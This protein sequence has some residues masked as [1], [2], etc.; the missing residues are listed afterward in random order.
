MTAPLSPPE[1]I[2]IHEAEPDR[3]EPRTRRKLMFFD[4]VKVLII[5]AVVLGY[6]I[7]LRHS[8]VP[9]MSW[10]DAAREQVEDKWWILVLAGIEVVRQI[11][12][13]MSEHWVRYH[14]FWTHHA[15]GRWNRFWDRRNP[16]LRFRLARLVR[17]TIWLVIVLYIFSAIWGVGF[18]TAIAEAPHHLLYEPFGDRGLPFF[19]QIFFSLAFGMFQ[20]IGIFYLLSRG[21]IE[22]F[23]P[24]DITTRFSD[25][26]GQDKVLARVRE[27]V[28]FLDKP[29][30]IESKGGHVPGGILLWR[31][32]GT[33]KTLMAEAVAGE[34]GKPFVF[35]EPGAFINMFF[36]IGILKV[37]LL[38]RRLR[39]LS[40]RY[41][42]V[43]AFYDEADTL[44]N[45]GMTSGEFIR[46]RADEL[47][48]NSCNGTHYLSMNAQAL[49]AEDL[50]A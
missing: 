44:G 20:F 2:T 21:G 6:V 46:T 40:L 47:G 12:N 15:W 31:P 50:F 17:V 14:G 1:V 27:N 5:L 34:T 38:F 24:Q 3:R 4:R 16:W 30:E 10:S 49:L 43:I 36:G 48:L 32:P 9:I 39:K 29:E 11:H 22:T 25:V 23:M 7:A 35:V 26:Y 45:R 37:A 19:F 8:Q 33:G 13:L 28:M 42:G 41:G 18:V